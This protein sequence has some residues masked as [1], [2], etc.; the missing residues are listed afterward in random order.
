[1]QLT[2]LDGNAMV[3]ASWNLM[4]DLPSV[5]RA[6]GLRDEGCLDGADGL[7]ERELV[8]GVNVKTSAVS[9][10]YRWCRGMCVTTSQSVIDEVCDEI[11]C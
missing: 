11:G 6:K 5:G 1:M 8:I 2:Y 7:L 4:P 10:R 3:T 9:V